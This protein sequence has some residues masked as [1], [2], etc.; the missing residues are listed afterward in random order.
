MHKIEFSGEVT[1]P[2]A[3][4][5]TPVVMGNL[6]P[7]PFPFP[8]QNRWVMAPGGTTGNPACL[9]A[10]KIGADGVIRAA[11]FNNNDNPTLIWLDGVSVPL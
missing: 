2:A 4:T 3:L 8:D 9:V 7:D 10:V 11:A 6:P 5:V 1:N